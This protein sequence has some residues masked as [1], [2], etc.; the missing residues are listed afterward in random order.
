MSVLTR[1]SCLHCTFNFKQGYLLFPHL[2]LITFLCFYPNSWKCQWKKH[3]YISYR[4]MSV[5]K[6]H[7]GIGC[8][9]HLS[10]FLAT[11]HWFQQG[12]YSRKIMDQL[13]CFHQDHVWIGQMRA[14]SAIPTWRHVNSSGASTCNRQLKSRGGT[15]SRCARSRGWVELTQWCVSKLDVY[16]K[17]VVSCLR[18][19]CWVQFAL[20][21]F[22]TVISFVPIPILLAPPTVFRML[23]LKELQECWSLSCQWCFLSVRNF[24]GQKCL[25]HN[26]FQCWIK[27]THRALLQKEWPPPTP[28]PHPAPFCFLFCIPICTE[29]LF[30]TR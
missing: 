4:K 29:L 27:V 22:Q 9:A 8:C 12:C 2:N 23:K 13:L 3:R 1:Y 17:M 10:L 30:S 24:W 11:F 18:R 20:A 19:N 6:S 7:N 16:A 14:H 15:C 21:R 28:L 25:L 5:Y 26:Y